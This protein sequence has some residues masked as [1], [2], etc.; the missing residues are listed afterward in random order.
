MGRIYVV[1][2]IDHENAFI[3]SVSEYAQQHSLEVKEVSLTYPPLQDFIV[4]RRVE[5][6]YLL[7]YLSPAFAKRSRAF[8]LEGESETTVAESNIKALLFIYSRPD[9]T[10]D[11]DLW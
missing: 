9:S 3:P 10:N 2:V 11:L 5:C 8:I 6:A 4:K 7:G 1:G